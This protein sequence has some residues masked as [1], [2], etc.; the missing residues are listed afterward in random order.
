M[1]KA[2]STAGAALTPFSIV[3]ASPCSVIQAKADPR[4][5]ILEGKHRGEEMET[6]CSTGRE[7][8]P[9][10]PCLWGVREVQTDCKLIPRG[11]AVKLL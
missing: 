4:G 2:E 9:P 5:E 3:P 8:D 1:G 7:R 6:S 11:S 10:F